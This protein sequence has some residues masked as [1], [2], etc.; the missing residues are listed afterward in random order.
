[1]A[2]LIPNFE[3]HSKDP[4]KLFTTL[5]ASAEEYAYI[6]MKAEKEIVGTITGISEGGTGFSTY[7]SWPDGHKQMWFEG[8]KEKFKKEKV[9]VGILFSEAWTVKDAVGRDE[10][11]AIQD[12]LK[13]GG[14]LEFWP[15][16]IEVFFVKVF[17]G[18]HY[19]KNIYFMD[20]DTADLTL[21]VD[22]VTTFTK[23]PI[24]NIE[25]RSNLIRLLS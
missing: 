20:R 13:A 19:Q 5:I 14:S 6:C 15:D 25:I 22:K 16:R 1:M 18:N 3:K 8:L 7:M 24:E 23:Y 4:E 2:I 21:D 17:D 12:F 10:A 9:K 11:Q